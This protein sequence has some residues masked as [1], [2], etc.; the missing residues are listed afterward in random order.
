[1]HDVCVTPVCTGPHSGDAYMYA[2]LA[3]DFVQM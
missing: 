3:V 2:W 1:M